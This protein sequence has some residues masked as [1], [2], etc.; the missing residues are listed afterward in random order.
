MDAYL[1]FG[2]DHPSE[3]LLAFMAKA[4]GVM[5]YGHRASDV[6]SGATGSKGPQTFAVL[7]RLIAAL[8]DQG[9][10]RPGDAG[11]TAELVWAAGHGL[12]MLLINFPQFDWSD[13]EALIDGMIDL[14]LNGLLADAAR[15][16]PG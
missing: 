6:D 13:R 10:L 14:P 12:V 5:P 3:Y 1:R 7:E 16:S 9:V 2:L 11:L 8:I 15:G 4:E